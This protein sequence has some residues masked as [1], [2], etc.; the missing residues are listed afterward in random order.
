VLLSRGKFIA[1]IKAAISRAFG[2]FSQSSAGPVFPLRLFHASKIRAACGK[3]GDHFHTLHRERGRRLW[4]ACTRLI[5]QKIK[6][7]LF[8]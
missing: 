7:R 3:Q 2:G 4:T 8:Y 5:F 1:R 6:Q